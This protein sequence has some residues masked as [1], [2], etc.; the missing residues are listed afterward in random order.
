[1]MQTSAPLEQM[2]GYR[3]SL[4]REIVPV[5]ALMLILI[6]ACFFA[7]FRDA[8][9]IALAIPMAAAVGG[10]L[11]VAH[12]FVRV[13]LILFAGLGVVVTALSYA[14]LLHQDLTLLFNP[15]A[16]PQQAFHTV[17]VAFL[18]PLFAYYHERVDRGD[19]LYR[20]LE[21]VALTCAISGKVVVLIVFES[22]AENNGLGL[23]QLINADA[24]IAFVVVRRWILNE[25]IEPQFRIL[26]GLALV[27]TTSG[28]FQSILLAIS[29]VLLIVMSRS[30]R[31][32]TISIVTGLVLAPLFLIPFMEEIF[33]W[34]PNTG[35]R[36]AFWKDVIERTWE[37]RGLGVGFGTETIRPRYYWE[38]G[39]N[40]IA[41]LESERF[42]YVA[43]HNAFFDAMYRMGVLGLLILAYFLGSTCLRL[44]RSARLRVFDCWIIVATFLTL[45][46]NV[47]LVSVNF[48]F[49]TCFIIGW[50]VY[51]ARVID[52]HP[53]SPNDLPV[54]A[55]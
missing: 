19:R 54:N 50:L 5:F 43:A 42:I 49:G 4:G 32:L 15:A 24:V 37:S 17:A 16:I 51:R 47:A 26:I 45:S 2:A 40:V 14:G 10:C 52:R 30:K 33:L 3:G 23:S 46:V 44:L 38:F 13:S 6:Y 8:G 22:R 28:A 53:A 20:A 41:P 21:L 34:D 31:T 7:V 18:I 27:L 25:A 1:M 9:V 48:V 11:L 29:L 12:A 35:I 39:Y 55:G 36:L